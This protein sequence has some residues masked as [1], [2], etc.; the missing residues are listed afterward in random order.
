MI[1]LCVYIAPIIVCANSNYLTTRCLSLPTCKACSPIGVV[2][3]KMNYIELK[4]KIIFYLQIRFLSIDFNPLSRH[5]LNTKEHRYFLDCLNL[6][7]S[8]NLLKFFTLS[9]R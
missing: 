5:L 8:P 4:L 9:K 3:E 2:A 6:G 7:G 1:C